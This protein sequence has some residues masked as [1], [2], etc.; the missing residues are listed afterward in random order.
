MNRLHRMRLAELEAVSDII[1]SAKENAS[2]PVSVIEIGGGNGFLAKEMSVKGLSV[3]SFDP[4]PRHPLHFLVQESFG[5]DL[6]IDDGT[7]DVVLAA[8]VMEHIPEQFLGPTFHEIRRVLKPSGQVIVFLPTSAAMFFTILFQPVGNFRRLLIH[9]K[10]LAGFGG[11]L[12]KY[13]CNNPLRTQEE[14]VGVK[15]VKGLT[16]RWLVPAPHGVGKSALHEL[17]NWRRS[18]WIATFNRSGFRVL[19]VRS[20]GLAFSLHQLGG[21][22]LWSLRRILGQL[23]MS[24]SIVFLLGPEPK[25]TEGKD[26]VATDEE[27]SDNAFP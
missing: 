3:R 17:W 7:A 16:L 20:G 13:P 24:G 12:K 21:E 6:P 18:N 15:L 4:N 27:R 11:S 9:L 1:E 2:V 23:G 26:I 25:R 5:H 14:S 22:R 10:R 8:H 19:D